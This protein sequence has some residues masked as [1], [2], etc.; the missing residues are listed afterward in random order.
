MIKLGLNSMQDKKIKKELTRLQE[1]YRL[2]SEPDN[3]LTDLNLIME[4]KFKKC[5]KHQKRKYFFCDDHRETSL[6]CNNCCEDHILDKNQK[7]SQKDID[8]H[9]LYYF[10]SFIIKQ[11]EDQMIDLNIIRKTKAKVTTVC[12]AIINKK[13]YLDYN[14][15][16]IK[17]IIDN[18]FNELSQFLLEYKKE[19]KKTLSDKYKKYVKFKINK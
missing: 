14:Y 1:I 19:I 6:M 9:S 11:F 2:F 16:Y 5:E 7:I 13:K 4:E 8:K 10:P 18:K 15:Y 17:R 3:K 12:D